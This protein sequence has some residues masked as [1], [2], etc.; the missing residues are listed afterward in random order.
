MLCSEG[1]AGFRIY[2]HI[3]KGSEAE[4]FESSDLEDAL[5]SAI[6][7]RLTPAELNTIPLPHP[8]AWNDNTVQS[9][10]NEKTFLSELFSS[11]V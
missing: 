10:I 7:I 1:I 11:L 4:N 5:K 3:K 8:T 9:R 2:I 6:V